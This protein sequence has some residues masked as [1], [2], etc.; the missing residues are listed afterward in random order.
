MSARAFGSGTVSFGLVS[1]PV[2]IYTTHKPGSAVTFNMLHQSCGTRLKQQYV[3]PE[4]D[5][6][7]PRENI[8]KGYEHQ[9]GKYVVLT[10]DEIRA[11]E[12]VSDNT[13]A[14]SEFVPAESVDPL[15][16]EKSYYLGPEKGSER[17]YALLSQAMTETGLIG[18]ARYSAR[19]K[20]YVVAVRPFGDSGL[21]LHQLRYQDEV[22]PFTEVP[23]GDAPGVSEPELELAKQIIEHIASDEFDPEAYIDEVKERVLAL[24]GDKLAG[25]EI[26]APPEPPQG[27][28]IDLMEALQASLGASQ[29]ARASRPAHLRKP[30]KAAPRPVDR[31]GKSITSRSAT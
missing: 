18:I 13:V 27:E 12:A 17:A 11:L 10:D 23:L 9:K 30:A 20:Q 5:E 25:H 26:V 31:P 1:I 29:A 24:I 15:Y 22:R 21:I 2:K 16:V 6:V 14:L 4:D 3:C 28:V 7:V 19:G 8:V